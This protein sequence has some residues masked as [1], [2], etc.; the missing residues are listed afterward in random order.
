MSIENT[1]SVTVTENI[2]TRDDDAEFAALVAAEEKAEQEKL[3]VAPDVTVKSPGPVWEQFLALLA[4]VIKSTRARVKDCKGWVVLEGRSGNRIA[5]QKSTRQLP[6]IETTLDLPADLDEVVEKITNGRMVT[7]LL[8]RPDVVIT[9]LEML[10]DTS[11]PIRSK[12][13]GKS[14]SGFPALADLL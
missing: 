4:P 12:R 7:V 10:A 14:S 1:S 3:S 6:R 5:V 9:A 8:P 13:S 2:V 11:S